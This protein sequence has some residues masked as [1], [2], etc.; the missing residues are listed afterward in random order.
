MQPFKGTI[1]YA[2]KKAQQDKLYKEGREV[3]VT[4]YHSAHYLGNNFMDID[5][6]SSGTN[7]IHLRLAC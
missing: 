2:S 1:Y 3:T 5:L 6:D 7:Y 4:N